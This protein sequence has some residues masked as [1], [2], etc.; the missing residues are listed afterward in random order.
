MIETGANV[1]RET[2]ERLAAALLCD[3]ADL[4]KPEEPTVTLRLSEIPAELLA[5]LQRQ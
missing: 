3:V 1:S 2:A 5:T 4:M